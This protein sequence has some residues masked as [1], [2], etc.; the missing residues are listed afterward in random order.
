M[1][2]I[3]PGD[4][5]A[6]ESI[7]R[8]GRPIVEVGIGEGDDTEGVESIAE[9]SVTFGSSLVEF[10]KT[11]LPASTTGRS[12]VPVKTTVTCWVELSLKGEPA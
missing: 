10:A 4:G 7:E 9:L 1:R 2:G 3:L 8:G 5:L 11:E 6:R 12:L